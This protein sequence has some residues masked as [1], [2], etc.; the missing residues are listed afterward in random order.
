[1]LQD[2]DHTLRAAS[3]EVGKERTESLIDRETYLI[4]SR[5]NVV[6][7]KFVE[8]VDIDHALRAAGGQVGGV[9]R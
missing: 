9:D 1:M 3:R 6:G 7:A 2:N 5:I 8:V 4:W